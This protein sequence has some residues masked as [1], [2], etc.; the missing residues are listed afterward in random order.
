MGDPSGS[1]ARG[2]PP[3][4]QSEAERSSKSERGE[5]GLDV[6]VWTMYL[7]AHLDHMRG[8]RYH[9]FVKG[10]GALQSQEDT[11][12][13]VTLDQGLALGKCSSNMGLMTN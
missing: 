2:K 9:C 1:R 6:K 8:A 10:R 3:I 11:A 13:P 12:L 4:S 7:I 5:S